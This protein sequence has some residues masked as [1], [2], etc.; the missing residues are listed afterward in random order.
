MQINVTHMTLYSMNFD[1]STA[2]LVLS[3]SRGL[4]NDFATLM[5]MMKYVMT[6][7]RNYHVI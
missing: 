6:I 5:C 3:S 2:S 4:I 7:V 1:V